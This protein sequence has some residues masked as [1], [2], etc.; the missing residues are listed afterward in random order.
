MAYGSSQAKG[1]T[2]AAAVSL[3]HIHGNTGSLTHWA[4]PGMECASSW[5]LS[6]SLPLSHKGNS[7]T[8]I[9]NRKK[10]LLWT[11]LRRRHLNKD[12][13]RAG[14]L[15][16]KILRERRG[17]SQFKGPEV[18]RKGQK[19]H[20]NWSKGNEGRTQERKAG[21]LG[22]RVFRDECSF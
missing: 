18:R 5:I 4:R 19:G 8:A 10:S 17:K 3:S 22:D 9:L 6:D 14:G 7:T 15:A 1:P 2:G 13:K 20:S 16:L 12:W 11:S 21:W